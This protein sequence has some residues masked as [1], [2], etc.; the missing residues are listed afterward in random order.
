MM[1]IATSANEEPRAEEGTQRMVFTDEKKTDAPPGCPSASRSP[2][3]AA[4]NAGQGRTVELI[5][6]LAKDPERLALVVKVLE[7]PRRGLDSLDLLIR[8]PRTPLAS[9]QQYQAL[10]ASLEAYVLEVEGKKS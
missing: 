8:N 5:A 2:S 6:A 1:A 10:R 9:R 4:K 7:N 3:G